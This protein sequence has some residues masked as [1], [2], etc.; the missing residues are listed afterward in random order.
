MSKKNEEEIARLMAQCESA[1]V[2][3]ANRTGASVF[4]EALDQPVRQ[5][6]K[7]AAAISDQALAKMTQDLASSSDEALQ[8]MADLDAKLAAKTD[9]LNQLKAEREALEGEQEQLRQDGLTVKRKAMY[10]EP[11]GPRKANPVPE[12]KSAATKE[13]IISD[14]PIVLD[15]VSFGSRR[16]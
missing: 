10:R 16:R 13:P 9:A 8:R 3:H 4:A 1:L 6:A 7:Q 5:T 11:K 14:E 15:K 2:K 12:R